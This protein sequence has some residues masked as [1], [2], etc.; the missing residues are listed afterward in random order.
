MFKCVSHPLLLLL[1]L[2]FV[3][4]QSSCVTVGDSNL[5]QTNPQ[6]HALQACD[7]TGPL[8]LI[9][10][11]IKDWQISS[12]SVYPEEWDKGC[13]E[14]HARVYQPD[15]LGWCAKYKSASEW[16]QV[17]L[18]VAAKITGVL[19]QGRNDG[20]E[21]VTSFMVSHSMDA[22]QWMYI[23]DLYGNQKVFE[24]NDDSYAVKHSYLDEPIIARYIKFHT[25]TWNKHPSMRVEIIGCQ[26]CNMPIA[27]PPFGKLSASSEKW[28]SDGSSCHADDGYILTN[29][30]WCAK[31]DNINQWLQFD[32]G[33]PTVI[34]G[35]ITKG[36]GD[37]QKRHW[38][39]RFRLSYSND[40][41][42][43]YFYKDASHL[44]IKE[45]GANSDKDEERY[46]YL[47]SPFMARYVRFHPVDWHRHISM[48]AGLIGCPF[49]GE[50]SAGFMRVNEYTPCVENLAFKKESWLNNRRQLKRHVRNQ[51]LHGHASRAVDGQ[52]SEVG[53]SSCTI[54]D[55]FYVDRPVWMVDLGKRTHISGIMI[56][57]W[58]GKDSSADT[59][60]TYR[61][62]M[63]NLDKLVVYVD[64]KAG[65]EPFDLE[66]NTCGFVSRLNDALFKPRLHVQCKRPMKGRYLYIE[67]WGV[68]NR[69]SR[70]FSA[71]LCE[72]L[73]YE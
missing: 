65:R 35:L 19:T 47:N 27:L 12:S 26:V 3:S 14:R 68:A 2:L 22:Y 71:V 54:L 11:Q 20:S 29:K 60:A 18:G 46:H 30:A 36:R 4:F 72:V 40:S 53:L 33:P 69:H 67:A 41:N 6:I 56:H 31:Q 15:G 43:W 34:T 13:H 55:N 7:Q 50:C 42:V 44:D 38:V 51:W 57:T 37:S 59:R 10:G 23:T 70:L 49:R 5:L 39:T 58:L 52:A 17:D 66:P 73:V 24:G 62:Y 63:Y 61:D 48:R 8:G 25:V 9:T 28:Q 45:F 64:N 32:V 21:W 1:L 16:L